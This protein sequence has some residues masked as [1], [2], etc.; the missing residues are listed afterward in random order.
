MTQMLALDPTE[1]KSL[2]SLEIYINAFK[3][4]TILGY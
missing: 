4:K 1:L 2:V 3:E